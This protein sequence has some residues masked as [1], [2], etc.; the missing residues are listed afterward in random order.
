MNRAAAGIVSEVSELAWIG[1]GSRGQLLGER[2]FAGNRL[3]QIAEF[4]IVASPV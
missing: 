3:L 4:V 2:F 1:G